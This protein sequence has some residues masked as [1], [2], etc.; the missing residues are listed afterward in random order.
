MR[1]RI[2]LYV[3]VFLLAVA[4]ALPVKAEAAGL[5]YVAL[6][7]S[8]AAGQ[9][10]NKEIG[11]GYADLIALSLQQSGSLA[12][13]SKNW[14]F[15]GYTT[16]QVLEQLDK[17]GAQ[18]DVRKA[19]IITISAGANDLLP[20]IRN[21]S[22]RGMLSYEPIPAAFALNRVRKTYIQL[23]DKIEKLNPHAEVYA[24]G[25][26][27][28]YPHVKE[29]HKPSV[30]KQLG[31]LNQII[32]QEAERAGA[33]FVPVSSRF[34]N[35]AK[36]LLPNPKDVH[37]NTAGY[38]QMANSFLDVYTPGSPDIPEQVLNT[39]PAPIPFS[40]LTSNEKEEEKEA[41]KEEE[42]KAEVAMVDQ[43]I[44][45]CKRGEELLVRR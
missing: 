14:A 20:L 6:G 42:A 40:K 13:F 16:E 15:P 32:K 31:I 36:S 7:D 22:V 8:L 34:G 41:E 2:C 26:Y 24:M 21:D 29:Q 10:P 5:H 19:N 11:A 12:S 9:T 39:L 43:P 27:F 1:K 18:Q 35:S 38:L 23:L 30:E 44:N 45:G 25:Y 37:P 3:V 33:H 28:P 17:K 4:T